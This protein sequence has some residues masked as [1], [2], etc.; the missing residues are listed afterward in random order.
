MEKEV[1]VADNLTMPVNEIIQRYSSYRTEI[2]YADTSL[3]KSS[4]YCSFD[5][6]QRGTKLVIKDNGINQNMVVETLFSALSGHPIICHKVS[7]QFEITNPKGVH[8]RAA[9]QIV[10]ICFQ[11]MSDIVLEFRGLSVDGK[12]IMQVT[13][14]SATCGSKI[15]AHAFGPDAPELINALRDLITLRHFDESLYEY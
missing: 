1:V 14:L 12:S 11:F 10:D 2:T 6:V 13:M 4:F 5:K 9:M 15:D 7:G 3:S 8:G